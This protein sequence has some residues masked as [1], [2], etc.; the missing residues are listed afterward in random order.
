MT[1]QHHPGDGSDANRSGRSPAT[2]DQAPSRRRSP[3]RW[4]LDVPLIWK[5]GVALVLGVVVGLVV[6]P[7]VTVIEPLGEI[8]LR[9]LMMLVMPLILLTLISGVASVSPKTLGRVGGKIFVFYLVTTA[10]AISLGIGLALLISPGAG[11]TLTGDEEAEAQEAPGLAEVFTNIVPENIFTALSEGEILAVMFFAIIAGIALSYMQDSTDERLAGLASL[12]RRITEGGLEI[13]FLLIRGILQYSPIGVFALIA[14]AVGETGADALLPLA[15]LTGVMYGGI[16]LQIVVYTLI[17]LVFRAQIGRFF[18]AA[19]EPMLTAFV[20]RSSGGTLPVSTQAAQQLGVR[21][22][23]YSFTLPFGATVNMDGTAIYVGAATVFVANVTGT[24]LTLLQLVTIALVGVLASIGTAGVPGAGL[25]MLT[26]TVT[27]AG[28]PMA[29]VALVAGI[30]AILDM[31]R[32]M[33]NVTGDLVGTRIV[34]QTEE[35]MLVD[36]STED[37]PDEEPHTPGADP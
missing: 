24:E 35:G 36:G 3:W 32:T 1:E 12:L 22:S 14:V 30:D 15:A 23:V 7:P 4:Y 28:L 25:I 29:P 26:M 34:A 10:F 19:K 17:L 9:L 31:G 37:E 21:K 11:L 6:G 27:S 33:C 5:L 18:K 20:T 8:F 2:A 16:A 13:I